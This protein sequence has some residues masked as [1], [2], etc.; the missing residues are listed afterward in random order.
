MTITYYG[1]S[2]FGI[3]I[4]NTYLLFDP[5][6][7]GNPLAN[8]ISIE[9][10]PAD[11]ILLSHG[12]SDHMLD[13]EAIAIRTGANVISNYE[14]HDWLNRK[15]VSNTH[16]MNT[17]GSWAFD[18]FTVK[19]V[20]AQHSSVLPD[21]TYGGNPM[22]FLIQAE[23]KSLYY[24]GDTALTMDMKL[25]P[26]WCQLDAAFLPIGNNFTMGVDDAVIAA[27]FIQCTNIIGMHFDTFGY[28]RIQHEEALKKFADANCRLTLPVIGQS[29]SL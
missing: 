12:H 20:V 26:M 21:G 16:P 8:E 28:I 6:I 15:G 27:D 4:Q 10:I 29:F 1:H 7:T 11:Y 5:F 9:N 23:H 25:L 2:C 3:Q 17:G 14:I 24:A 22:G 18:E 13:T 19:C